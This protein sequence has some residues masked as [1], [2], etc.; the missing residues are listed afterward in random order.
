MDVEQKP[1]AAL[2]ENAY[3]IY[4]FGK[5]LFFCPLNGFLLLP[6]GSVYYIQ[7]HIS[8]LHYDHDCKLPQ[9]DNFIYAPQ[10]IV[11]RLYRT[12]YNAAKQKQLHHRQGSDQKLLLSS[13]K[14]K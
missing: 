2:V 10:S 8:T 13:L 6:R 14:E 11:R 4:A 9:N 7:F 12:N 5:T 3:L 1:Q